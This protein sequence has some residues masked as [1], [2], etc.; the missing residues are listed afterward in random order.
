MLRSNWKPPSLE[1]EIAFSYETVAEANAVVDAISPDNVRIPE[2]LTIK[3]IRQGRKVL[4]NIECEAGLLTFIATIDDLLEAISIAERSV[5][6]VE[7]KRTIHE[8]LFT[9][10]VT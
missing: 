4:T 10:R 1:A 8:P 6:A 7:K 9:S 5:S 2:D 3:T